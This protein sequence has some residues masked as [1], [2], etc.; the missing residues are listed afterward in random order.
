MNLKVRWKYF[1]NH[2]N[3]VIRTATR[4]PG[5]LFF[6]FSVNAHRV[7]IHNPL[8]HHTRI[9]SH[10]LI[11]SRRYGSW[12][13]LADM[14]RGMLSEKLARGYGSWMWTLLADMVRG[15]AV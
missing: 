7:K 1:D 9:L 5:C 4:R 10:M 11:P 12:T 13:L 14:F 6:S 2:G 15:R 3:I 8:E